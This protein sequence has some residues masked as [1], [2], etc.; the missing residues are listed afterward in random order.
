[1]PSSPFR[2]TIISHNHSLLNYVIL[3]DDDDDRIVLVE[4]TKS[5]STAQHLQE[6]PQIG[7]GYRRRSRRRPITSLGGKLSLRLARS[8][9]FMVNS[10]LS[11]TAL[12]TS[13]V[14]TSQLCE[15]RINKRLFL[16]S[17]VNDL[18]ARAIIIFGC[19]DESSLA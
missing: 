5:P 18:C 7:R 15:E 19:S 9:V 14:L 17:D 4:I 6:A 2:S 10:F 13:P 12:G 8:Y 1:M 16:A 3:D 11:V